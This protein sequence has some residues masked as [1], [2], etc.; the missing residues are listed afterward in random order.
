MQFCLIFSAMGRPAVPKAIP[1][2]HFQQLFTRSANWNG[3]A[4]LQKGQ[5]GTFCSAG[6]QYRDSWNSALSVHSTCSRDWRSRTASTTSSWFSF[7]SATGSISGGCG[8]PCASA[9]S[10]TPMR[11]PLA[12]QT[13][14]RD[15]ESASL[16]V[17][18]G[19]SFP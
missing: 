4:M 11:D 6:R 12:S 17:Y 10:C 5:E 3:D 13:R 2:S 1:P 9:T 8:S 7:K 19:V 16:A 14:Q 18:C 15:G